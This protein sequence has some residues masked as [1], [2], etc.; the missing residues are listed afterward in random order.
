MRKV[1][2]LFALVAG[3][4]LFAAACGSDNGTGTN[5]GDPLTAQEALDVFTQLNL[6]ISQAL[7]GITAPP[8][9][10]GAAMEPIPEVSANCPGGGSVTVSGDVTSNIDQ[11]TLEGN[12]TFDFTESISNCVVTSAGKSFTV[13]G[14]PNISIAGDFDISQ[15][16]VS[17]TGTYDLSGGFR[18]EGDGRTGSCAM[19][20]SVNFS[21]LS[22]SGSVCGNSISG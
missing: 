22:V 7:G 19:N 8:A 20:V 16:P 1:A 6:A 12:I 9:S 11:Q 15:N 14:D 13:N 17:I 18:Y 21:N 3:L 10:P 4:A 5:S 2:R